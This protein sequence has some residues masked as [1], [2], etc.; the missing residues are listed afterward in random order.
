MKCKYCNQEF[1]LPVGSFANHVRW[2]KSNPDAEK[3]RQNNREMRTELGDLKF[4]LVKD[5]TVVCEKCG[6]SFTVEKLYPKKDKYFCSRKCANAVGGRAKADKHH[7]DETARYTAVA[8]RHHKKECIVCGEDLIVAVHHYNEN[9]DDN[10]PT[11]LV[12]LCPTHH[13]YMHSQYKHLIQN[14]V[15]QYVKQ[16]WS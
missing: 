14:Q 8:W 15:D 3:L 10:N 4:G 12:P 13:I 5:F 2:C 9:H 1:D 6:V 11:N 7:P 16:R